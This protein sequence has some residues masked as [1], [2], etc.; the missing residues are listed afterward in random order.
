MTY[1]TEGKSPLEHFNLVMDEIRAS[2][3]LTSDTNGNGW[4]GSK[5]FERWKLKFAPAH[6]D[7]VS[8]LLVIVSYSGTYKIDVENYELLLKATYGECTLL[9]EPDSN[10]KVQGPGT[11]TMVEFLG[12]IQWGKNFV[13]TDRIGQEEMTKIIYGEAV[14]GQE[15]DQIHIIGHG[16][17]KGKG[18]M[19]F[20]PSDDEG[21]RPGVDSGRFF[22]KE[23]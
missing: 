8:V 20:Y 10:V 15:Y 6:V 17:D 13:R 2:R 4:V 9:G 11:F 12:T 23:K 16:D 19:L 1:R 5:D 18:G 3:G 21:K 14:L 7:G 22:K